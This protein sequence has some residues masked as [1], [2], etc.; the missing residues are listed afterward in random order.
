VETELTSE[1]VKHSGTPNSMPWWILCTLL[2]VAVI[3]G[4]GFVLWKFRNGLLSRKPNYTVSSGTTVNFGY[5]ATYR[6]VQHMLTSVAAPTQIYFHKSKYINDRVIQLIE[7]HP[8]LNIVGFEDTKI[9]DRSLISL[10]TIPNLTHLYLNQAEITDEG[11]RPLQNCVELKVLELPSTTING[12]GLVY[13]EQLPKLSELELSYTNITDAPWFRVRGFQ[14]L[15]FLNLSGTKVTDDCLEPISAFK[16]LEVLNLKYVQDIQGSGLHHLKQL[17]K[18]WSLCLT[19]TSVGHNALL[20]LQNF[21][22]LKRLDV[23][24]TQITSESAFLLASYTN[25]DSQNVQDDVY[26]YFRV[27][28]E[29]NLTI[30]SNRQRG[31]RIQTLFPLRMIPP[32]DE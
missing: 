3:A 22:K 25:M 21:R 4:G 18:L 26:K 17:P 20:E 1:P 7:S 15:R 6:D 9:T 11:L 31:V 13:L 28:H 23:Y 10:A 32:L 5:D 16:N 12:E 30:N 14:S 2:L 29:K 24:D 27:I 8:S 19:R